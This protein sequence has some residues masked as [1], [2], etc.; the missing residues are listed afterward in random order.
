D[1]NYVAAQRSGTSTLGGRAVDPPAL[2]S[3]SV[4]TVTTADLFADLTKGVQTLLSDRATF[5]LDRKAGLLQVTDFPE[6][7]DRVADYLDAV[8][9]RVQRQVELDAR[10]VETE[11][12]DAAATGVDWRLVATGVGDGSTPAPS[13]P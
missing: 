13:A 10:I 6:R 11:L 2:S 12:Q 1:I 3:A 7:L 9:G 5:N 4:S 8:E